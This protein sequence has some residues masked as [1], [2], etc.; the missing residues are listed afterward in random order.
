MSEPVSVTDGKKLM[1]DYRLD[2]ET[3]LTVGDQLN[4]LLSKES[5]SKKLKLRVLMLFLHQNLP[6]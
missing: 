6:I 5:F 4:S 1:D 2:P 3:S